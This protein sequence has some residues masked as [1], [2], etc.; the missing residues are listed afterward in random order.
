M[1]AW[2]SRL[3]EVELGGGQTQVRPYEV[4]YNEDGKPVA[5]TGHPVIIYGDTREEV[6]REIAHAADTALL[7]TLR[8][9][10]FYRPDQTPKEDK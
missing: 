9:S 3:V 1:T 5:R 10:A 6:E 8:D 2:N 4:Y 7:S